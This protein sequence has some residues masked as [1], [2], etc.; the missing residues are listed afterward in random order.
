MLSMML[1][2]LRS[3]VQ[4]LLFAGPLL[5]TCSTALAQHCDSSACCMV[6]QPCAQIF[7]PDLRLGDPPELQL[8][9]AHTL[10]QI[11][12]TLHGNHSCLVFLIRPGAHCVTSCWVC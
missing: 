7:V 2:I 6:A 8:Q 5:L 4:G 12:T 11:G 9:H 3:K 10:L 1:S